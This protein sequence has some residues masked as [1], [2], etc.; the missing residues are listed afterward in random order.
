[1]ESLLD[2]R[3]RSCCDDRLR[4]DRRMAPDEPAKAEYVAQVE[5]ICQ[6]NTDANKRSSPGP[7][8]RSKARRAGTGRA[9]VHPRRDRRSAGD[10]R[11]DRSRASPAGR[12]DAAERNGST[13]LGIVEAYL[14]KIG[15]ALKRGDR[16]HATDR[17][18]RDA[19]RRQRRQQRRLRLRIPLLPAT[20][21]TV[22]PSELVC[23]LGGARRQARRRPAGEHAA[24]QARRDDA[25]HGGDRVGTRDVALGPCRPGRRRRSPRRPAPAWRRSSGSALSRAAR[26]PGSPRS[27]RSRAGPGRRGRRAGRSSA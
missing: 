26:S 9:A 25:Q 12:S 24:H 2:A 20:R 11:N 23:R 8:T 14:R 27:R 17:L 3:H 21:A 13:H 4:A 6:A 18:H 10:R 7:A 16:R 22:P 19:Q 5:P 1:M 15:K